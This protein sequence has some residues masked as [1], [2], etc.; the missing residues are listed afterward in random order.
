MTLEYSKK[1]MQQFFKPKNFGTIKNA[2]A[3]GKVGNAVCGDIMEIQLKI[4]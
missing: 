1:T 3:I 2:D 4:D